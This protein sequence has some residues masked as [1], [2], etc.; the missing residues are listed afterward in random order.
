MV[1]FV[2]GTLIK[3]GILA[4]VLLWLLP[5]VG[6]EVPL[7]ITAGI[8]AALVIWSVLTYKPIRRVL[9]ARAPSPA[10]AMIGRKGTAVTELAPR[11][12]VR[13]HGELWQAISEND[14]VICPGEEVTVVGIGGLKLTVRKQQHRK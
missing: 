14:E 11:G 3:I 8:L 7:E 1:P 9:K 13:I 4:L 12:T 6:L 10:E 2:L 5:H